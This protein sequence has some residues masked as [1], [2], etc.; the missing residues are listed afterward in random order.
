MNGNLHSAAPPLGSRLVKIDADR[1]MAE[2]ERVLRTAGNDAGHRE[3][4]V[5][6]RRCQSD[7]RLDRSS[8]QRASDLVWSF[9]ANGWDEV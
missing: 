7:P 9:Q 6:L 2:W 8:R 1:Q 4:L 5:S 3:A